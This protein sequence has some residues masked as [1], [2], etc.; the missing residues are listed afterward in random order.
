[1]IIQI[2]NFKS[3]QTAKLD[4]KDGKVNMLSGESGKGKSTV[5]SAVMWCLYG[6]ISKSKSKS[7]VTIELQHIKIIR[8]S[9]PNKLEVF[10]KGNVYNDSEGQAI[11]VKYFGNKSIFTAGS[12]LEQR[13]DNYLFTTSF[14]SLKE[15]GF[16][17]ENIYEYGETLD[18]YLNVLS[19]K[20]ENGCQSIREKID[21]LNIDIA[22][23]GMD[24]SDLEQD[25]DMIIKERKC[26]T[27]KLQ[28]IKSL[29]Q[30]NSEKKGRKMAIAK[31][32]SEMNSVSCKV[33]IEELRLKLEESTRLFN[34]KDI[35]DYNEIKTEL[36]T[37][38]S[39]K[40]DYTEEDLSKAN[41]EDYEYKRTL[42]II[43]EVGLNKLEN[44]SC[45]SNSLEES[46]E[47][48]IKREIK[49]LSDISDQLPMCRLAHS[50]KSKKPKDFICGKVYE[51]DIKNLEKQR[52]AI[53]DELKDLEC[54]NCKCAL[55][56]NNDKLI[57]STNQSSTKRTIS[58]LAGIEAKLKNARIDF[59]TTRQ[60]DIYEKSV[61]QFEQEYKVS[62][63]SVSHPNEDVQLKLNK[64]KSIV[65]FVQ[66]N[67]EDIKLSIRKQKLLKQLESEVIVSAIDRE[68]SKSITSNS[69]FVL[70]K[71][72]QELE[73]KESHH[74]YEIETKQRLEKEL[75]SIQIDDTLDSEQFCVE[76][77]I[78]ELN[79]IIS[80][81]S[82]YD[83]ILQRQSQILE[84]RNNLVLLEEKI[85]TTKLIKTQITLLEQESLN[86][87][88]GCLDSMMRKFLSEMFDHHTEFKLI[89]GK[90]TSTGKIKTKFTYEIE[91]KDIT[92]TS[93]RDL[94]GGEQGR[95]NLALT[96]A[97]ASMTNS[98]FIMIDEVM[99]GLHMDLREKCIELMKSIG[100]TVICVDHGTVE[101]FYDQCV[102]V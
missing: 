27:E 37:L 28:N 8:Y 53:R 33:Y 29:V 63:N 67:T 54:P 42:Q 93:I 69:L 74:S 87:T 55:K 43:K 73:K 38:E 9:R 34:L 56:F 92:T 4:F 31:Q 51:E 68:R 85:K 48:L 19:L 64:L 97:I 50:I 17:E 98:S 39:V 78:N 70:K 32:L 35:P 75:S 99:S 84:E 13:C 60:F 66:P 91:C 61:V 26:L 89:S 15:I 23:S 65:Q 94:S 72:I 79:D 40:D 96:L 90:T 44:S 46:L 81:W 88:I 25:R 3:I 58:D 12:Y 83:D 45:N 71:E 49:S 30:L 20:F 22:S 21:K 5:F 1:M 7:K 57:K 10:N 101:G 52:D 11:I 80:K 76:Q 14:E 16:I 95:M 102:N 59:E 2:E 77:R 6:G 18:N 41:L 82:M 36:K 24:S 47:S 86:K 100:K 62:L